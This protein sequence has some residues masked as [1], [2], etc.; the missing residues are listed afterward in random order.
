LL[1][2]F[3][4]KL[5]FSLFLPFVFFGCDDLEAAQLAQLQNIQQHGEFVVATRYSPSIFYEGSYGLTGIEY[6]LVWF[7]AQG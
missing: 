5:L 4:S 3:G 7:F 1:A 6:D 2:D